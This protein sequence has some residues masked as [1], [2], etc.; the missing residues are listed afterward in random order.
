[1][2]L[3]Y[4]EQMK[5]SLPETLDALARERVMAVRIVPL[6]FGHGGHVKADLPKL[7]ETAHR[8]FPHIAITLDAP[9]GEQSAV[10][11]A[12]ANAIIGPAA[13]K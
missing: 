7:V 2:R 10:I 1:V 4:L 8:K 9:I 13:N 11:E 3:S 5:P 6:F 12:I